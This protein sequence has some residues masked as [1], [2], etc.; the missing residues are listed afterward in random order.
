MSICGQMGEWWRVRT[1]LAEG[2]AEPR[3]PLGPARPSHWLGVL[4]FRRRG[5]VTPRPCHTGGV[6]SAYDFG[7]PIFGAA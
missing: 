5:S 1:T 4:A 3:P 2:V 6:A 7:W